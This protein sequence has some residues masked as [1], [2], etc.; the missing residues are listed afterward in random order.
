MWLLLC[1]GVFCWLVYGILLGAGPI[2][3][4]NAVTLILAGS[5][6]VLKLMHG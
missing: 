1:T 4:A 6:L 3:V 5:V 2:I